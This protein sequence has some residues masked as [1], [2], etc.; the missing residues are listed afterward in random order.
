MFGDRYFGLRFFGKHYWGTGAG[1]A[2]PVTPPILGVGSGYAGGGTGYAASK[3]Q[4]EIEAKVDELIDSLLEEQPAVEAPQ[5]QTEYV[6]KPTTPKRQNVP[7][8]GPIRAPVVA[9][10]PQFEIPRSPSWSPKADDGDDET[11]LLLC[12]AAAMNQ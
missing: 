7:L 1:V 4:R 9:Q 11:R 3:E 8:P 6:A 12:A 5:N 10:I 2:E